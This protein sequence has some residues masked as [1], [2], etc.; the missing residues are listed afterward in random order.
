MDNMQIGPAGGNGGKPFDHY[1]IPNGARLSAVHVY[2]EWVINAL[3]F[4]FTDDAPGSRPPVGSPG[5]EHHVFTLDEDEYL[6]G[7]SGRAGWYVDS[8]R[9]H[10][11]KRAS[12]LFGGRGPRCPG[13]AVRAARAADQS[14]QSPHWTRRPSPRTSWRSRR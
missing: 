12:A 13:I 6:T 3:Q 11:N 5:G 14:W 1:N 9:F 4:E 8:V 2:C 7:I 10:T